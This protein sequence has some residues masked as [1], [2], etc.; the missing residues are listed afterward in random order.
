MDID[1]HFRS[2]TE[3]IYSHVEIDEIRYKEFFGADSLELNINSLGDDTKLRLDL[4]RILSVLKYRDPLSLTS[5]VNGDVIQFDVKTSNILDSLESLEL[6][7][8]VEP[9]GDKVYMHIEHQDI[10]MF[11][12]DWK[13][14]GSN[15]IVIGDKYFEI[16]DLAMSDGHREIIVSGSSN[17]LQANFKNLDFLL[18]NG[19]INYDKIEFAG[20]GDMQVSV[21]NLLDKP[22]LNL[23][24]IVPEF[25][26][27]Q[28]DYGT[29][30]ASIT[31]RNDGEVNAIVML[32]KPEDEMIVKVNAGLTKETKALDGDITIRNLGMEIFEFIIDDGISRTS[33]EAIIDAEISGTLDSIGLNGVATIQDGY[34]QI[35][36]LANYLILG[37]EEIRITDTYIDLNNLTL[38]DRL[39][40]VATMEGGLNHVL[41]ADF[42]SDLT[43][44]SERFLALDTDKFDNPL[45]YGTGIGDMTV[46]FFGPFHSTDIEV[47]AI[48]GE[49]TTLNI[50]VEDSYDN[51]NE[52]FIKFVDRDA[53]VDSLTLAQRIEGVKLEG[54]DVEMNL[55]VTQDADVN[56]IFNEATNDVIR[57]KGEGDLRVVVSREGDFNVFGDYEVYSGEYLFRAWGV[58]TKPFVVKQGGLITW[59]GDPINA[60]LNIEADYEDVRVPTNIFLSEYIETAS[61]ALRQES[62][63]RTDVDLTMK[64]TGTLYNPVIN[65]DIAFPE[66]QGELRSFADAKM[67]TLYENEAD[68]NEQV[69]GLIIF[70][71]FLP[72]NSFGNVVATGRGVVETGY[73]TLSEFISNQLSFWISGILQESLKDEGF[74]SGIDFEI[75]ISKNASL[76]D[77]IDNQ[78]NDNYLPDEI[79]VNFKPRFQNDKWGIDYGTSF[80]NTQNSTNRGTYLIHDFALEYF[81]TDDRRLKLR[82]YGKWDR[83]E[84]YNQNEQRYGV[85][86]N[87]RKEFGNLVDFKKS[88]KEDISNQLRGEGTQ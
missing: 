55:T 17:E 75:G 31:D 65:F 34:T 76:L 38:T 54:V 80:V 57:G 3:E 24:M 73:N 82:I 46:S 56:I 78:V 35:D 79:E 42:T 11:G 15:D 77:G 60:N 70:R 25:T 36:Y 1:G 37:N 66:L 52:S 9:R 33:G 81:L 49:G 8:Q 39:G 22:R 44:S 27:N 61:P 63:K 29:L 59:T 62:R 20:E 64:L 83:D 48:T 7:V 43:M 68:L 30:T 45:Y 18:I 16:K 72:S 10:N 5:D 6:H 40:N 51:Y 14:S 86:I 21:Q 19:F 53:P 74:I 67:R 2:G 41:F 71:T 85:G 88:F 12:S 23:D 32:D 4:N 84:F 13:I 58:V 26:L 28:V 87:Y 50:P 47:E 69:A